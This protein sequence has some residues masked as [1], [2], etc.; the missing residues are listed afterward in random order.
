MSAHSRFVRALER[1][2]SAAITAA[3]ERGVI[4]EQAHTEAFETV[5]HR[6]RAVLD[7]LS[8]VGLYPWRDEEARAA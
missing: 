7:R 2:Y 1:E 8:E 5:K 3:N 6:G 4:G